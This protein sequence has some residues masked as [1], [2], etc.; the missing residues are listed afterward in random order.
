MAKIA[1]LYPSDGLGRL[2]GPK[3]ER[4]A[5]LFAHGTLEVEFYAPRGTDPQ[6]PHKRDELYVVQSG[7]GTFWDGMTRRPF[8]TGDLLFVAAG[9][10]HRFENFTND[11]AAWVVFYGPEGGET[12]ELPGIPD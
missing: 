4:Y 12:E 6:T 3:G 8:T 5:K 9:V 7:Q 2:P 11:F 1:H 10:P